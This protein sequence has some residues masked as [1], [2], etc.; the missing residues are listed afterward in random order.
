MNAATY[1]T[2][3]A[4]GIAAVLYAMLAFIL[5]GLFRKLENVGWHFKAIESLGD[6]NGTSCKTSDSRFT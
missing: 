4:F 2:F 5:I 6:I 3:N 1:D